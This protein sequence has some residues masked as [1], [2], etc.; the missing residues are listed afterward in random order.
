MALYL[1]VR[2]FGGEEPRTSSRLIADNAAQL[3]ENSKLLSGE[4]RPF[5]DPRTVNT[6]YKT[7]ALQSIFLYKD[8]YWC[9][10]E[11]DVCVQR[12]PVA[13]DTKERTYITGLDVPRVFNSDGVA[14]GGSSDYPALTYPLGVPAP[15]NSGSTFTAT[16]TGTGGS[17]ADRDVV[18]CYTYVTAWGEEGPISETSNAVTCMNGEQVDLTNITPCPSGR[19]LDKIRIYRSLS[20]YSSDYWARV[21]EV[22]GTTTSYSD[23]VL[24]DMLGAELTSLT[25]LAPDEDLHGI[26][27]HP[28]GFLVGFFDN[29]ISCSVPYFP[30]AWPVANQYTIPYDIMGIGVYEDKI[31]VATTAFPY[32]F[33]GSSPSALRGDRIPSRQ[34]CLSRRGVVSGELGVLWPSPDGIYGVGPQGT[35]LI[36]S[37]ILTKNEWNKFNPQTIHAAVADNKYIAFY[38]T[39]VD[40]GVISGRGFSV[41]L[42]EPT[43]KF[44]E[45]DFYAHALYADP[46]TDNLY[47]A[48]RN[49]DED[50]NYIQKWEGGSTRKQF[51]WRSKTFGC[52]PT[53]PAAAQVIADFTPSEAEF[54]QA[55]LDDFEAARDIIIADNEDLITYDQTRGY[56]SGQMFGEYVFSG[57]AIKEAG[58]IFSDTTYLNFKLI[59]DGIVVF[60]KAISDCEP[61]RIPS[62]FL[63]RELAFELEGNAFIKNVSVASS[64]T[65]I[66]QAGY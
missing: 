7:D 46:Y 5:Y 34:P 53:N 33:S 59:A 24:D 30:H 1:N 55:E 13:G 31:V 57:S 43:A 51:T 22:A 21:A 56:M 37:D 20:G 38:K 63:A 65:T 8:A 62:N 41:D 2:G 36:T 25:W 42:A 60:Q 6:P 12:G 19:N 17:G 40:G 50:G 49:E 66:Y 32:V 44:I 47:M 35:G 54:T 4:I 45:F 23:T 39:S 64:V 26:C 27:A 15:D 3:A 52:V 61:F 11:E 9:H 10:W 14:S 58:D 48:M 18:Y 29:T 28:G 16:D